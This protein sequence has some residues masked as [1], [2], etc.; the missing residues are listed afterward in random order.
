MLPTVPSFTHYAGY[1]AAAFPLWSWGTL[2]GARCL[3]CK[4][5]VM[6]HASRTKARIHGSSIHWLLHR[7]LHWHRMVVRGK[8]WCGHGHRHGRRHWSLVRCIRSTK[9]C[10]TLILRKGMGTDIRTTRL[11]FSLHRLTVAKFLVA[12]FRLRLRASF[13]RTIHHLRRFCSRS[14]IL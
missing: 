2:N 7:L 8:F 12:T 14:F 4:M 1:S 3:R 6:N 9:D 11:L 5:R 10:A 13:A